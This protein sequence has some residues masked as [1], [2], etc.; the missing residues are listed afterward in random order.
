MAAR[1]ARQAASSRLRVACPER[2]AAAAGARRSRGRRLAALAR[3]RQRP[4]TAPHGGSAV[5]PVSKEL[6]A[7]PMPRRCC[8][9]VC[10]G[11]NGRS[12]LPTAAGNRSPNRYPAPAPSLPDRAAEAA[13]RSILRASPCL[14]RAGGGTRQMPVLAG[15]VV[16]QPGPAADS[17]AQQRMPGGR[18]SAPAAGSHPASA[19]NAGSITRGQNAAVRSIVLRRPARAPHRRGR[20]APRTSA[21]T[22][23]AR[24]ARAGWGPASTAARS[25]AGS[26]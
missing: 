24:P 13:R 5:T 19:R 10:G 2:R 14:A 6:A 26:G 4:R 7:S 17:A 16:W 18:T 9:S 3:C 21:L 11:H 23:P 20:H 8:W 25:R 22:G 15:A 1:S 12:R